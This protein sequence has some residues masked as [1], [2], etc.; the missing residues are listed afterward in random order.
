ML[1]HNIRLTF[2][3]I[4][5][6]K[7]NAVINILG[8]AVGMA[9]VI[10]IL[11]FVQHELSYDK[12]NSKYERIYRLTSK[13]DNKEYGIN[14]RLET[15]SFKNKLPEIEEVTQLYRSY[16]IVEFES[17]RFTSLVQ[18][19]ADPN[20]HKI[21]DL[22]FIYGEAETA[23]NQ[24]NAL[25]IT[26][27]TAQL[28][29][30]EI[31]PLGKQIL[32]DE[33]ISTIG[34]VVRNLPVTSHYHFDILIGM[35][36]NLELETL[37]GLEFPT[38]ILLKKGV[39]K[40][41]AL[42]KA[43]ELYNKIISKKARAYGAEGSGKFEALTDIHLHSRVH[44]HLGYQGSFISVII[45]LS[46]A[47]IILMIALINFINIMT[48]QYETKMAEIG[49]RKAIGAN[50]KQLI[51]QFLGNSFILTGIAFLLAI[52]LSEIF[53]PSFNHLVNRKLTPDYIN[54]IFCSLSLLL[55]IF[56]TGLISGIYPAFY[57]SKFKA[58][59]ILKGTIN[60]N[61]GTSKLTKTLVIFQFTISIVLITNLMIIR[62]QLHH[63]ENTKL[64]FHPEQVISIEGLSQRL[65]KSYPYIKDELLKNPRIISV[66]A[67][68]HYPGGGTSG[69]AFCLKGQD[70][71]EQKGCD[72]YRV[73]P[74]YFKT[75]GIELISGRVFSEQIESD[76]NN[77]ILNEKAA[78]MFSK[79]NLIGQEVIFDTDKCIIQGIVK[80]F[81]FE[82]L[83]TNIKPLMFSYRSFTLNGILI[84]YSGHTLGNLKNEIEKIL[85][86]FDPI[87]NLNYQMIEDLNR[88]RYRSE[89]NSK[90]ISTYASTLSILLALLGLYALTLS[91]V[92][93]RTKE[94]GIRKVTGASVFQISSLFLG[95]FSKWIVIAF[96]I[97]IPLS[98]YSMSLW[99]EEFAYRINI[100]IAPFLIAGITTLLVA[101]LTVGLQTWKAANRNSI[102]SLRYE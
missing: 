17:K 36:S 16:P 93:K 15:N 67:S 50:R 39:D 54:N 61:R 42:H 1:W 91:M 11:L 70:P 88:N 97:A 25:V 90:K 38:Y 18:Y 5:K 77:I 68:D 80:D 10:L 95:T 35:V 3:G 48:V 92:Q 9:A 51:T 65:I 83:R 64:G 62:Q 4:L 8:L 33:T 44:N 58:S 23:F 89:K 75:L 12:F 30:G 56:F 76:K 94:I 46:L 74:D 41:E 47:L 45:L 57:I 53:L 27:K 66:S 37:G 34:G 73:Q 59:D 6:D 13:I 101:C 7:Q 100:G 49:L 28:I 14:L 72:E 22:D 24:L 102:E 81:N 2:R 98:W 85:R 55:M 31:N 99:L 87:Y 19:Y 96:I 60:R 79:T 86:K 71:N 63:L 40:K 78:K 32:I 21:F 26:E 29:F 43:S 52:I 84:K 20:F 82:S 69:Q